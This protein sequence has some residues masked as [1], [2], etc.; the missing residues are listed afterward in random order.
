M[1]R[2]LFR[3]QFWRWRYREMRRRAIAA[4]RRL[5]AEMWRNRAREDELITVPMR[6]SGLFGMMPRDAPAPVK[7]VK[8]QPPLLQTSNGV[9]SWTWADQQEF[10][11]FW[12]PEGADAAT[13]RQM[14]ERFHN[15]VIVPRR[16]PFNDDNFS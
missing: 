8:Q 5:E 2:R 3:W 7:Q 14:K 4:E 1:I 15:E 13:V 11:M 6:M 16:Q 9:D 12:K 10:E